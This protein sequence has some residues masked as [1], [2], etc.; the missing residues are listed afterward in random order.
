MGEMIEYP[1][2][3]TSGQGYL[4]TPPGGGGPGVVVVQEYWGLVPHIEDVCDRFAAEGFHA[5]AP[6]FYHGE[7]A[8]EPDDAGRLMMAM[9][10]PKAA[11]DFSGAV[12]VLLER[13]GR[14][15]VG[16]VGFCM[17]GGL[18]LVL[19]T[20]RPDAVRA[21]VPF[22][23]LIPWPDA[24]PDWTALNGAVL[25]HFAEDDA[26]ASPSYVAALETSLREAGNDDV[27]IYTYPGT[28]HAFFNDARPEVYDAEASRLA[29]ERTL[30]FLR[31]RLA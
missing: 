5:L 12:D 25:G 1:S 8:T 11:K 31:A 6:D 17:G 26:F 28:K 30:E 18:A 15:A 4:A 13:S 22:Y 23:G 14:P 19:A 27:T 21:V 16:A 2:N 20:H 9:E 29:W 10:L 7:S 24:Q 3:G